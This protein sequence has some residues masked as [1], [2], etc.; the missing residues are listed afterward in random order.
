MLIDR[1]D[2]ADGAVVIAAPSAGAGIA[3]S[4]VRAGVDTG[5]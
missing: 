5:A 3:V 1:I 4:P 2:Q